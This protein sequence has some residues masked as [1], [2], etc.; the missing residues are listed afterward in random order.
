VKGQTKFILEDPNR[1]AAQWVEE[2]Q[3]ITEELP[4]PAGAYLSNIRYSQS[5]DLQDR[6]SQPQLHHHH[7][8]N[9]HQHKI[10]KADAK[11]PGGDAA[12]AF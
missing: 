8:N 1:Q 4:E 7:Q 12:S 10:R 9:K 11:A 2:F 6:K 3:R 5:M